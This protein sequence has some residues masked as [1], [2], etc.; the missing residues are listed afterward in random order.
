MRTI[1]YKEYQA[2]VEYDDGAL[3]VKILHI[4]DVLV[5]MCNSAS[6]AESC[7]RELIDDYIRDCADEGREPARPFKGS[8]NVRVS[9][10]MHKRAAMSAAED[11]VSMNAWIAS[12]I[13]DK[14]ECTK[15]SERLD[16]VVRDS[17]QDI[18][19]HLTSIVS[20]W[21]QNN[22][23]TSQNIHKYKSSGWENRAHDE[24]LERIVISMA[25]RRGL[26][27]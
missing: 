9:P 19:L 17:R 5:A 1:N 15:L 12:A 16:G 22:I 18:S 7:A 20:S 23:G 10:E 6:D 4:P 3:F 14:L 13:Q 27:A 8:F 25:S 24:D 21:N 11:G 2:S 26:H